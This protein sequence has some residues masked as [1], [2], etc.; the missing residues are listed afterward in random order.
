MAGIHGGVQARIKDVNKKALF[1]GCGSN[2]INLCG[3]H[4]FAENASCVSSFGTLQ[5]QLNEH[6]RNRKNM[7]YLLK[8]EL[9]GRK[10]CQGNKHK[11][12]E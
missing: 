4:S 12:K 7:K 8:G 2:S 1:N 9:G 6:L 3:Q 10:Q 5:A 11:M